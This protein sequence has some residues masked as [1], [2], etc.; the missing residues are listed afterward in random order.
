MPFSSRYK[1]KQALVN[2]S[3]KYAPFRNSRGIKTLVQH[4]TFD[5]KNIENI[6]KSNLFKVNHVVQPFETL[7]LISQ[8]YY[9]AP[10][11]GWLICATNTIPNEMFITEGTGLII[12]LPLQEVLG[13]LNA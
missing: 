2:N 12:Y 6:L 11:Y 5:L 4:Q 3:D 9:N 13:I 8:K 7:P 1:N 10:E